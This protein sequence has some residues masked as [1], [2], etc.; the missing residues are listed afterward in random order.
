M[1]EIETSFSHYLRK[2]NKFIIQHT[3]KETGI[4]LVILG[5]ES[6]L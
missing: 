1:K 5:K 3:L 6:K 4:T 2:V